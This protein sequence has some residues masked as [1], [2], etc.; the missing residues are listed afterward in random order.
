[1][2]T[3]GQDSGDSGEGGPLGGSEEP[4]QGGCPTLP[5]CAEGKAGEV[6]QPLTFRRGPKYEVWREISQL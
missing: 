2:Q 1:M 6:C 3:S 5:L 4:P